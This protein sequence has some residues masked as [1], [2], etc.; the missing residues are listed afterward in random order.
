MLKISRIQA[1]FPEKLITIISII[2]FSG[3]ILA[4]SARLR[5]FD[6]TT[7]DRFIQSIYLVVYIFAAIFFIVDK[8]SF[9]P[10]LRWAWLIII[11]T[12]FATISFYWSGSPSLT[13][14]R[15]IALIGTTLFAFY[16]VRRY[17][18]SQFL[19]LILV[20][21]IF[22]VAASIL[23]ALIV[24][25]LGIDSTINYVAWRGIFTQK[26][27]MGRAMGTGFLISFTLFLTTSKR[28][29]WK[30]IYLGL[31]IV[32]FCMI[33]LAETVTV[34]L[35]VLLVVCIIIGIRIIR[36]GVSYR[37]ASII[38]LFLAGMGY[39][40]WLIIPSQ[41]YVSFLSLFGKNLSLTGRRPLWNVL[42]R[43]GESNKWVGHGYSGFWLGENGA[44][45][46]VLRA[47]T[48]DINHAHNGLIDIWLDLGYVGV[49]LCVLVI[50]SA[51]IPAWRLFLRLPDQVSIWYFIFIIYTITVNITQGFLL[52]RNEFLWILF[53]ASTLYCMKDWKQFNANSR[54]PVQ[55]SSR[56]YP[57]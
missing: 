50:L 19:Q 11:L 20:A 28:S 39:G 25:S 24:P 12:A 49:A 10:H 8:K 1:N 43:I 26:N 17:T 37:K 40:L 6:P 31:T 16:A 2:F 36:R 15:S 46:G 51:L 21:H 30:T 52:V 29:Q 56:I 57:S 54:P 27:A 33:L 35:S 7:G 13:L 44:S 23:L 38:T 22:S 3:G 42:F 18:L 48:W 4:L 41:V 14:R 45:A 9:W 53:I 55:L 34:A 32:S 5:G 47:F